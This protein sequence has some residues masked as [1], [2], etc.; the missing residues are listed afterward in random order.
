MIANS[1]VFTKLQ[2]IGSCQPS[3]RISRFICRS[4]CRDWVVGFLTLLKAIHNL[5][6][7]LGEEG[8]A[9]PTGRYHLGLH[10]SRT[11]RAST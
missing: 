9:P 10:G 2:S 7:A 11:N 6:A 4:G 1:E 8:T 5:A 3:K